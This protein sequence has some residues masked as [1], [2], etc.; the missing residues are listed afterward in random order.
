MLTAKTIISVHGNQ[1]HH[2]P[3][4]MTPISR[5]SSILDASSKLLFVFEG[6]VT[7]EPASKNNYLKR[8]A[9][10]IKILTEHSILFF[11]QGKKNLI[12]KKEKKNMINIVF[13]SPRLF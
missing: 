4:P 2:L 7:T 13:F 5:S 11:F 3:L 8:R 1:L 10:F 9:L 6:L 12:W